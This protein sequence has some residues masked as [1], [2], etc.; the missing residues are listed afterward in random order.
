MPHYYFDIRRYGVIEPDPKGRHLPD[1]TAAR[2]EAAV[3]AVE[4]VTSAG[5]AEIPDF[6]IAVRDESGQV[7]HAVGSSLASPATTN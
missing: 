4:M 5:P 2:A 6:K 3:A 7:R 1:A